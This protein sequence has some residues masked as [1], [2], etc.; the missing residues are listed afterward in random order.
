MILPRMNRIARKRPRLI[1]RQKSASCCLLRQPN[2]GRNRPGIPVRSPRRR[3]R[4]PE[5]L[6]RCGAQF[7]P[8]RGIGNYEQRGTGISLPPTLPS[9]HLPAR[10]LLVAGAEAT[11]RQDSCGPGSD[12]TRRQAASPQRMAV[13]YGVHPRTSRRSGMAGQ[14]KRRTFVSLGRGQG[15]KEEQSTTSKPGHPN[16]IVDCTASMTMPDNM[17]FRGYVVTFPWGKPLEQGVCWGIQG[18]LG[19]ILLSGALSASNRHAF[20]PVLS[21][22]FLY[23]FL[24]SEGFRCA[25]Y[26]SYHKITIPF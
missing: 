4:P 22:P 19:L 24:D 15:Q 13:R 25:R 17:E 6:R 23:P 10:G 2:R 8:N 21:V 3:F 14:I 7:E 18:E 1:N 12:Q 9:I 16:C 11:P 5:Q 26:C 20:F